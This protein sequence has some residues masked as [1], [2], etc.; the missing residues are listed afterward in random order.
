[1]AFCSLSSASELHDKRSPGAAESMC[2]AVLEREHVH[3]C[4]GCP[5]RSDALWTRH[6]HAS[7]N[8]D[9]MPYLQLPAHGAI[10]AW[11]SNL[12]GIVKSLCLSH[13]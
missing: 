2:L 9:V 7:C 13:D 5:R 4:Q 6:V 12:L 3:G 1:M 8:V 10:V 11:M